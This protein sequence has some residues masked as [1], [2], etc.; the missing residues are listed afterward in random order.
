MLRKFFVPRVI[1]AHSVG[2]LKERNKEKEKME[3]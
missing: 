3:K 2:K 1:V